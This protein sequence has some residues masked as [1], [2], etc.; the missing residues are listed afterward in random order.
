MSYS[1]ITSMFNY[2]MDNVMRMKEFK[3]QKATT[4]NLTQC[5]FIQSHIQIHVVLQ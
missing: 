4:R 3:T 1:L 2:S 5:F